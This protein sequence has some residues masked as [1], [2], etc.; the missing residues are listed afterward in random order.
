[1][2]TLRIL[3]TRGIPGR[4]GGFETFATQLALYLAPR[5]WNVTVYCQVDTDPNAPQAAPTDWQEDTWNGIRR[6]HVPTGGDGPRAA[7]LYDWKCVRHARQ[8]DGAI[9]T[10]GYNTAVFSV[11]YNGKIGEHI[12]NMDGIE[13]R[14]AKWP[15]PVKCWFFLNELAGCWLA[16][17]LVADNPHIK[18]HLMRWVPERKITMLP[19]TGDSDPDVSLSEVE[20]IPTLRDIGLKPGRFALLIARPEPENSVYELVV[21]YARRHRGMPLIV[22]G[23]YQPELRSYHRKVFEAANSEVIFVGG[24]YD[25]QVLLALRHHAA[26]YLHG[27][28]VGGTNPSLVEAL[29]AGTPTLAHGNAYN[30]WVAG[31]GAA[32][33]TNWRE[34]D[35]RLDQLL[36]SASERSALS[37][38]AKRRFAEAFTSDIVLG[39]YETMLAE[40]VADH[41]RRHGL[42]RPAAATGDGIVVNDGGTT[43]VSYKEFVE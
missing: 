1:V 38:A 36:T 3:G 4:H 9:L 15:F 21:A 33:F 12:M 43:S 13:W 20:R 29:A 19:Y 23:N 16:D 2:K 26:L 39:D 24:I 37:A 32:Y 14:R 10:L 35:E 5:G 42:D 7:V 18:K 17:H 27:H 22:L 34:A 40:R 8:S 41:A 11:L 25:K 30:R 28:T 6:I 31:D